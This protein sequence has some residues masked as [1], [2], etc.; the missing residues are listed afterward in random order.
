MDPVHKEL[1]T[2]TCTTKINAH[3]NDKLWAQSIK[4]EIFLHRKFL[5]LRYD[6]AVHGKDTRNKRTV[7]YKKNL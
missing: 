4:R 2:P 6:S 5:R 7:H 3:E 1:T